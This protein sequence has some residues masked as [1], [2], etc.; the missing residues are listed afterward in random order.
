MKENKKTSLTKYVQGSEWCILFWF[1]AFSE[2]A[3]LYGFEENKELENLIIDVAHILQ[4]NEDVQGLLKTMPQKEMEKAEV[5]WKITKQ[6]VLYCKSK[7]KLHELQPEEDSFLSTLPQKKEKSLQSGTKV[8]PFDVSVQFPN[9]CEL[10]K[11]QTDLF[12]ERL[13]DIKV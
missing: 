1:C 11:T 9:F 4:E 7:E 13:V 6:I 5:F 3:L 8:R 10:Q 12:L 2:H